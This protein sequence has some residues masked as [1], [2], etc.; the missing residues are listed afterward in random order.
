[1]AWKEHANHLHADVEE[2]NEKSIE[3]IQMLEDSADELRPLVNPM[4]DNILKRVF[5]CLG[6]A[7]KMLQD[8]DTSSDAGE[9][10]DDEESPD[11]TRPMITAS[12]REENPEEWQRLFDAKPE[13]CPVCLEGDFTTERTWDS[14]LNSSLPT[15]CIHWTCNECWQRIAE[16][17]QR[18]PIC[19]DDVSVWLSRYDV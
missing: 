7:Q 4:T 17:D 18:C 12:W 13:T 15:K 14:P 9:I 2:T 1:M 11:D 6:R 5:N 19:R 3:V 10:S 8:G 16:N